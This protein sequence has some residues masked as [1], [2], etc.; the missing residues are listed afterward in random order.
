MYIEFER[1]FDGVISSSEVNNSPVI[2]S[3]FKTL[4]TFSKDIFR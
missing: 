2:K 4:G 1:K 3:V